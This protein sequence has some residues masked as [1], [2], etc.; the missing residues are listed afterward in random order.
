MNKCLILV[1]KVLP[2]LYFISTACLAQVKDI[3]AIAGFDVF[4]PDI[5]HGMLDSIIY[6]SRVV[7]N[8]RKALVS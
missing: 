6:E 2:L 4:K 1:C 5:K 3:Q 8:S 7:G